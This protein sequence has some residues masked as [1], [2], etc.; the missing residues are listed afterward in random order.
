M[1]AYSRQLYTAPAVQKKSKYF[2]SK[3][4][5]FGIVQNLDVMWMSRQGW[6]VA[7]SSGKDGMWLAQV[8]GEDGN[9]DVDVKARM[10]CGWLKW[11]ECSGVLCDKKMPL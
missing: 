4:H 3:I 5:L 1:H 6:H 7:G 2:L 8:L 9:T 11:Q 10:A